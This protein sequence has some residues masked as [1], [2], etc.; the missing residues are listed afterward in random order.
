MG[1]SQDSHKP[2]GRARFPHLPRGTG[3]IAAIRPA[4]TAPK[5]VP[6]SVGSK[7]AK[8]RGGLGPGPPESLA[9]LGIGG[10]AS[11]HAHSLS[12]STRLTVPQA[13]IRGALGAVSW[14]E[15]GQ[16]T[17]TS[18]RAALPASRAQLWRV[19]KHQCG[20]WASP[21]RPWESE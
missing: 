4:P 17:V 3:H 10:T 7:E 2:R 11:L 12:T 21:A 19:G 15:R 16:V 6:P 8:W 1:R 18:G 20:C 5:G 9:L 13:D 14:A